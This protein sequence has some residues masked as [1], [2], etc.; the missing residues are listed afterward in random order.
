MPQKSPDLAHAPE[1]GAPRPGWTPPAAKML[2]REC[3]PSAMPMLIRDIVRTHGPPPGVSLYDVT[4]WL[5]GR[6]GMTPNHGTAEFGGLLLLSNN[7][8]IAPCVQERRER[9]SQLSLSRLGDRM[10]IRSQGADIPPTR[11]KM[12]W[13][14]GSAMTEVMKQVHV[15]A[16]CS[17]FAR[18]P[19]CIRPPSCPMID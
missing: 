18:V 8:T 17:L 4:K 6:L 12:S 5:P 1:F 13:Q 9:F 16:W 14:P 7:S 10:P 19:V 2:G 11:G 15:T 3:R